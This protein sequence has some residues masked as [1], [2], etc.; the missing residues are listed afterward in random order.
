MTTREKK[1]NN[2]IQV[3]EENGVIYSGDIRWLAEQ[4]YIAT[5][6][7]YKYPLDD[8]DVSALIKIYEEVVRSGKNEVNVEQ[9]MDMGQSERLRMT[10]L[11]FHALVAKVKTPTGGQKGNCWLLTKRGSDFLHKRIKVPKWVETQDNKVIGHSKEWVGLADFRKLDNFAPTYEII[12]SKALI[13][14]YTLKKLFA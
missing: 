3:L 13:P 1:I 2:I 14:E 9:V 6:A 4:L 11:R 5:C 8:L 7:K 12:Q 10:Q